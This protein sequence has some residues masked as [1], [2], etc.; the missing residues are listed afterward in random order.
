MALT[1]TNSPPSRPHRI[2][3][4]TLLS[5]LGVDSFT[6]GRPGT[7]IYVF[8]SVYS[9][10]EISLGVGSGVVGLG[11]LVGIAYSFAGSYRGQSR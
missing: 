9:P 11:V 4:P 5:A 7:L 1:L 6:L 8:L 3:R 2:A 10:T